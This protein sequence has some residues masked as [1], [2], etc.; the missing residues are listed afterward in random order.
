LCGRHAP[1]KRLL[2]DVVGEGSL[3]VDLDD[4]D[5]LSIAGLQLRV[6]VDPDLRELEPELGAKRADLRERALAEVAALPVVDDY[7]RLRGRGHG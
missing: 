3:A 2:V 4:R 1:P 5:P 6:A 7:S